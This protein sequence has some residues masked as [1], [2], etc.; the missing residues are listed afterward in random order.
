M[1]E[2]V[3]KKN[4]RLITDFLND[5]TLEMKSK[6]SLISDQR[7]LYHMQEC[8]I[9]V[10]TLVTEQIGKKIQYMPT[11]DVVSPDE[12]LEEIHD[13][14]RCFKST[15]GDYLNGYMAALSAVEKMILDIQDKELK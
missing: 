4:L 11:E 10:L 1:E 7:I 14:K 5:T 3:N 6:Q 13:F 2:Y 15:N 9:E 8:N 12:L